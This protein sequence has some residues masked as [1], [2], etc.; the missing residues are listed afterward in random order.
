MLAPNACMSHASASFFFESKEYS[1]WV[2]TSKIIV[3]V[4]SPDDGVG[5]HLVALDVGRRGHG[6]GHAHA[7]AGA[8]RLHG[9]VG[10]RR[11]QQARRV[12]RVQRVRRES[13][14]SF[15]QSPGGESVILL[16]LL[17]A[18]SSW[19]WRSSPT[20]SPSST[21]PP[22]CA[23]PIRARRSHALRSAASRSGP[24]RRGP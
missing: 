22:R 5:A 14:A 1:R 9:D 10:R 24:S 11:V 21:S 13:D 23:A 7:L 8:R 3:R 12:R 19:A 20:R 2:S 4:V 16:L 6:A 17:R 15:S 18:T